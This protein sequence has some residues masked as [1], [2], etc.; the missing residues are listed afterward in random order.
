MFTF[1]VKGVDEL[2]TYLYTI[3]GR[4]S[5]MLQAMIDV[6]KVV[7]SNTLPLTPYETGRLGE[8]FRWQVLEYSKD[9]IEVEV[10]MDAVDPRDGYHY[11]EYQ[12]TGGCLCA[13]RGL[14][15]EVLRYLQEIQCVVYG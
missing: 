2:K 6:A 11:A 9:F 4:Y 5:V 15:E 12:H 1:E 7:E 13:G 14:S 3:K 8:S 10:I